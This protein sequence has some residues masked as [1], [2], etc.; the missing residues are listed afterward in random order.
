VFHSTFA[1]ADY[2]LQGA[3]VVPGGYVQPQGFSVMLTV[4]DAPEAERIFAGLAKEGTVRIP[5]QETSWAMR[6]GALVDQFGTPWTIN[7][8]KKA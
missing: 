7:C 2:V 6:F 5:L 1:L 8:G 3:D 4:S